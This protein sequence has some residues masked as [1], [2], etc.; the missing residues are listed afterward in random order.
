MLKFRKKPV[1]I[2]ADQFIK[3]INKPA[4]VLSCGDSDFPEYFHD[5]TMMRE[6][7][8][9]DFLIRTLEGFHIVSD[10]DW[11]IKGIEGEYYPCKPEIFKQTYERVT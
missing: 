3:G 6:T 8:E 11:I 9:D 7:D 2:E 1:I 5:G 4:I 10:G